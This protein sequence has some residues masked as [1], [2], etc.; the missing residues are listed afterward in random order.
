M[1]KLKY[2]LIFGDF[3]V[4]KYCLDNYYGKNFFQKDKKK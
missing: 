1:T 4:F 2:S 3:Y